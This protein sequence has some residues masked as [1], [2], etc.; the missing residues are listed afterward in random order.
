MTTNSSSTTVGM[1]GKDKKWGKLCLIIPIILL[2]SLAIS[3]WV[4]H[5]GNSF[6]KDSRESVI[7][8]LSVLIEDA[9][10]EAEKAQGEKDSAKKAEK[11]K[12]DTKRGKTETNIQ[13]PT[14]E[15][16]PS[17]TVKGLVSIV[18][19]IKSIWLA[20]SRYMQTM[21]DQDKKVFSELITMVDTSMGNKDYK[22]SLIHISEPTRP[23]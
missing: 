21:G 16:E 9:K 13:N 18:T 2:V 5:N 10:T 11:I 17:D 19:R 4:L 14:T 20:N 23:Y 3:Y 15:T 12:T 22:L 6:S 7:D 8:V 1:N